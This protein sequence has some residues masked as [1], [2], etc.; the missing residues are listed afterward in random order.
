MNE[1]LEMI[2][3]LLPLLAGFGVV[4]S[5]RINQKEILRRMGTIEASIDKAHERLDK[6]VLD[7][8]KSDWHKS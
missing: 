4:V 7:W 5:M 1:F 3:A 8:H 2:K 6:H